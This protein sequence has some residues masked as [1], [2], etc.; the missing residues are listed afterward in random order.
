[1]NITLNTPIAIGR[2][3][4]VYEWQEGAILKLYHEWC[5]PHWVE[6]EAKV[7]RAVVAAGIPTPAPLELLEVNG[8][9]GIV[10]ERVTGISMLQDLN[11]RPWL[12]FH[13]ARTLADLQA[14]THQLSISGLPSAKNGLAHAV[15]RAPHLEEELRERALDHLASLPDGEKV[16]HGDFH[17][18]NVMMTAKGVV[19]IDWMTAS[20]GNP[21]ADVART[22]MLLSIGAKNAGKMLSPM[23]R[24]FIRLYH[25]AYLDRY[26]S[27]IPDQDD[28]LKKWSPVIAAARLDERIDGE[29]EAL[30]EITRE[31][32]AA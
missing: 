27:L 14:R 4:E 17:P 13:F 29:H 28:E 15:R 2:T 6:N 23:V 20:A 8:R 12:I 31:G 11:A 3:A 5:P 7:A 26:R 30:I 19:I 22:S 21:W 9:R 25:Q 10:Y 16:C 24:L 32:L 1:M 18:G